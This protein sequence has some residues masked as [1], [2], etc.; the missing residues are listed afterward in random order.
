[1]Y[2]DQLFRSFRPL[3]NPIGFGAADFVLLALAL[4][5]AVGIALRASGSPYASRIAERTPVAMGVI[6]GAAVVLRLAL[7]RS[8]PIPEP[9]GADDFSYLLLGD[10]LRHFRMANAAHPLHQFFEAV[11]VLQQPTYSSIFPLGQG[12]VLAAGRIFL[13]SFWAGVLLSVAAFCALCYWMLRGWVSARWAFAGGL[14]AVCQFGPLS[15]WMNSYWGGAVSGCAGC[16]VFGALPRIDAALQGRNRVLATRYAALLGL[17]LGMQLL[18]RPFEFVLLLVCV[19]LYRLRR[20]SVRVAVVACFAFIPALGLMAM[21]NKSVSGSWTTLPYMVS[22]FQYGVPT[23]FTWQPVPVPHRPLT[24]EQDLDYRAQSAIHGS[25]P[26][27]AGKFLERLWFRVRFVRFFLL[28][29]LFFAAAAFLPSF[30]EKRFIWVA[31]TIAIFFVGTNFYPYFFAHYV[32]AIG[33]LFLLVAIRG[34][35]N[36]SRFSEGGSR[37][38]QLLCLLCAAHFV[39]WYGLRLSGNESLS[40]ATAYETWDFVNTGDPD[41]RIAL[42]ERLAKA[43][44]EQLVFVRYAP[45]HRFAEWIG[46]AA[47]I[48][49]SR[50]VW[51]LDLGAEENQ[52]LLRYFPARHAWLLEPDA[53]PPRLSILPNELPVAEQL[54]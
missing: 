11:F 38:A 6:A 5:L 27:T 28:A 49:R 45:Q 48:D 54:K 34:L 32:A 15:P 10:T 3:H 30:R 46:N 36:L 53:R 24:P 51:A 14:L 35:E 17:G 16:L 52:E 2:L 40:P 18:A 25:G 7:L 19:A 22:R 23:T 42:S 8:S 29:P 12:I 41:G 1:M 21:Q 9:S 43:P 44:G 33:S 39:F 26:D 37:A 4:L 31:G 20:L 50:V 47:D 13:G